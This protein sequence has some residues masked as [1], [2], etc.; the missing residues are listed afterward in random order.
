M[1]LLPN[2]CRL[3][4]QPRD[5]EFISQLLTG[6]SQAD[7]ALGSLLSDPGTLDAVLDQ[8]AIF[9]ALID[10]PDPLL[11]SPELYFYVLV[12]HQLKRAGIDDPAVA[13][14]VAATLAAHTGTVA[15]SGGQTVSRPGADFSYHIEFIEEMAGLSPTERFFLQ[16]R[17]GNHLLVLTG[18][19]PNFLRRRAERRGAP[20]VRYY[21]GVAR[22]AFLTAGSHPLAHEFD[23]AEVYAQLTDC[24][25]AMRK[26]LNQMAEDYLF[27]EN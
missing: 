23:V 1:N 7:Q 8:P 9:Q 17:C 4:L 3:N 18:L 16:V 21:E 5:L 13:D 11:V 6:D 10:Q 12:R 27:I 19:F 26:A 20:G 14:Y 15:K 22:E 24:F 2:S 25:R